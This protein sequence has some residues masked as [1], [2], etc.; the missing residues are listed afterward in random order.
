MS[1]HGEFR[2]VLRSVIS[3]ADNWPRKPDSRLKIETK[4]HGWLLPVLIQC[5]SACWGRWDHWF[6]TMEAGHILAEPIP[7]IDFQPDAAGLARKMHEKSLDAIARGSWLGWDSWR[8]FDYYLDWLL[9]AFGSPQQTEPPREV[10]DGAFARLYQVFCLEAMLAWPADLF[11]DMLAENRHGRANG[12]FPTPHSLVELMTKLTF[13][14]GGDH[15]LQ[16]VNDPCT[17]TGR[18]LLHASNHS[19]R[20]CGQDINA[21][22]L[23]ACAVNAY[24]FAPWIVRGFPF[25]KDE[26]PEAVEPVALPVALPEPAKTHVSAPIQLPAIAMKSV[27]KP[28]PK[29]RKQPE[30]AQ[31]TLFDF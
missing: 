19:Y 15:R 7:Q 26:A 17:G 2:N 22:V 5:E 8:I 27:P 13:G 20:L 1:S 12:F 4:P 18:M 14:D 25:L 3:K 10:E 24:C 29:P 31:M 16:T 23:K 6:R 30:P 21:T 9:Y 11:G 28:A